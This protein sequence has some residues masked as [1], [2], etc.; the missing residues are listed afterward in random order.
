MKLFYGSIRKKLI[1]LVL[2]ATTPALFV[3]FGQ[4]LVKRQHAIKEAQQDTALFL[5]GFVEI[6]KRITNST[7]TLLQT[8]ASMPDIREENV[9]RSQGILATLLKTNPIYSNI[10]LVNIKGNVVAA[11][12]RYDKI[13]HVNFADRKEFQEAIAAKGFTPGEFTEGTYTQQPI[14]RF[15]TAVLEENGNPQGV[16]ITGIDLTHYSGLFEHASYP[17]GTFLGLCDYK[18]VRLF[19]YPIS[20]KMAIGKPVNNKVFQAVSRTKAP[21]SIITRAADGRTRAV[22]FEPLRLGDAAVPYMYM[23]MGFDYEQIQNRAHAVFIRGSITILLSLALAL[24]IAWFIGGRGIALRIE[25]LTRATQRFAQ[26]KKN[27]ASE[28]DYNNGEVGKLAKSF[29]NMVLMLQQRED[30]RNTALEQLRKGEQRFREILEDLSVISVQGYDEKRR[31]TF[32][33]NASET[34][35][36]YTHKEALGKKLEDLIIP[37]TMKDEVIRLHGQWIEQGIKIPSGELTLVDKQGNDVP[38]FSS[39]VLNE[40]Q[41]GKEMFCVDLDLRPMKKAETEKEQLLNQLRQSQKMEAIGTLAGGIAHDFNNI[42]FPIL[43]CTEILL[44]ET[45]KEDIH[46]HESLNQ[47]HSSAMRARKLVQ[48]ILTF[49]RQKTT[50]YRPIKIQPI[51]EEVVELL[52]STIS[53]EIEIKLDADPNCR[54]IHGDSTQIHQ[55]VMNLVTNA[56]HAMAENGGQLSI[57]LRELDLSAE[58]A[59]ALPLKPGRV[60][61][62]LVTDTGVGMPPD[63]V[64]KIFDPFFTTKEKGKGTGMGLSVVHGIVTKMNGCIQVNSSP[65]KGTEFNIYFPIK[66]EH[67]LSNT[68]KT[69]FPPSLYPGTERIL[70]VDD[71][72]AI[73]SMVKKALEIQG[74]NVTAKNKPREALK[75]F[76]TTPDA[77]DMVISDMSMPGMSGDILAANMLEL[78][79]DVPILLCTGFSEKITP[80]RAKKMGIKDLLMKP[81]LL[82]ELAQT[83]RTILDE[84][85]DSKPTK[86]T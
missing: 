2:L 43:G 9:A 62:M 42:L 4:G 58:D 44:E 39:H 34:L 45:D 79:P 13:K 48:Q 41:A 70:L 23:F 60:A 47:I 46:T 59:K 54:A 55:I 12:K 81:V 30:E 74:Y 1:V 51:L 84:M 67:L 82:P 7:Q 76:A 32:W 21:G 52:R 77:F 18:G 78:R 14:F 26:G 27:V 49:S 37:E 53:Q 69:L 6:Q 28:I 29:D 16:L 5:K 36:G 85:A 73:L 56:S 86:N 63:L 15:A 33:N 40:T 22:V 31:V 68:E 17:E 25:E 71:D 10:L 20:E 64:A 83:I 57:N 24:A 8:V 66:P 75:T 11:G 80:E 38:V 35:Y 65:G 3:L 19:R 50:E 72:E 61:C